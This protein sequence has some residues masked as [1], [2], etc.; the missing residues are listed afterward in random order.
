V[1]RTYDNRHRLKTI[2]RPYQA[3]ASSIY[4]AARYEYD[5]L[6]RVIRVR[7]HDAS[8]SKAIT[9]TA[10][11]TNT[12]DENGIR[13]YVEVDPLGRLVKTGIYPQG[14]SGAAAFTTYAYDAWDQLRTVTGPLGNQVTLSYDVMGRRTSLQDKDFGP[15][16]TE[17][18][19]FDSVIATADAKG[20]RTELAYDTLGRLK[21]RTAQGV[22]D[23]FEYDPVNGRGQLAR[24]TRAGVTTAFQY[25]AFGRVQG[26]RW[27]I[28]GSS[29]DLDW[30]RLH[31]D[32]SNAWSSGRLR[33]VMG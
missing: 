1:D 17:Y 11:T 25:D 8:V 27:T 18:D 20:V 6:D 3:N 16:I 7:Q 15:K 12:Y 19:A 2:S 26:E 32:E 14:A 23:T 5:S 28:D 10:L 22:A 13:R 9:Y 29:Y 4:Q 30:V 24:R 31:G 33:R 21:T